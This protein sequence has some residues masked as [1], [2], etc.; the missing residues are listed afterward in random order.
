MEK[1]FQFPVKSGTPFDIKY[2]IDQNKAIKMTI[3]VDDK[4][5]GLQELEL[6]VYSD[7][8][9]VEKDYNLAMEV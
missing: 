5:H 6:S 9:I 8:K 7:M 2:T 3:V 1:E 4:I